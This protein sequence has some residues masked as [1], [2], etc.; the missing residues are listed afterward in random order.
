MSGKTMTHNDLLE[1]LGRAM[2]DDV[3]RQKLMADPKG[4]LTAEGYTPDEHM[5]GFFKALHSK[6]HAKAA[7][8]VKTDHKKSAIEFAGDM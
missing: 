3:F 5:I 4:A 1:M 8:H 2:H 7:R 6:D